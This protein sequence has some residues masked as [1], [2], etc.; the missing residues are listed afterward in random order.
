ML[1]F[2][3]AVAADKIKIEIVEASYS[4]PGPS[5]TTVPIG[6]TTTVPFHQDFFAKAI[7]PDGSH[8][9]LKCS[10]GDKGCGAIEPKVADKSSTCASDIHTVCRRNL[11]VYKT[12]RDGK[13][14][15]IYAPNG[16]RKYQIVG[17]W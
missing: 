1:F 6:H 11:G 16:K 9:S 5:I 12:K 2:A 8:A 13:Y 15:T 4:F 7:L 17:S 3:Q 10:T 14:L